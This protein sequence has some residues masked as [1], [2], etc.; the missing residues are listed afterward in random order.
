MEDL[1][2]Y[3]RRWDVWTAT[4]LAGAFRCLRQQIY[5]KEL[6]PV[7]PG[8]GAIR[9]SSVHAAASFNHRSKI[10]TGRDLPTREIVEYA[11]SQFT[12]GLQQGFRLTRDENSVGPTKSVAQ[13]KDSTAA[14][15]TTYAVGVAPQIEPVTF[16][17][18]K[19]VESR[20]VVKDTPIGEISGQIDVCSGSEDWMQLVDIKTGK[21][22]WTQKDIERDIQF[23]CY[24]WL[25]RQL[26][27][28]LP[29]EVVV[30]NL[31]ARGRANCEKSCLTTTITDRDI[32]TFLRRLDA[33]SRAI[34]AGA[35]LPASD[36]F[37][38]SEVMCGYFN[39]CEFITHSDR[40]AAAEKQD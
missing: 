23:A 35:Y 20:V 8:L 9:G 11:V 19:L 21:R 31:I 27:G 4:Q 7:P 17:G 5:Y 32:R 10:D 37:W 14:I 38:C 12:G 36:K 33:L 6:G 28:R 13:A 30:H 15:A 40:K 24:S 16:K 29:D 2:A 18:I 1:V 3:R 25:L 22:E 39:Q 34:K 26:T